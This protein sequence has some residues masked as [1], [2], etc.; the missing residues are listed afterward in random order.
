MVSLSKAN[1]IRSRDSFAAKLSERE[2]CDAAACKR[3]QHIRWLLTLLS[4]HQGL[5]SNS[6]LEFT[7]FRDLQLA[8]HLHCHLRRPNGIVIRQMFK[9]LP[10][11]L[12]A[13]RPNKIE[14]P[15]VLG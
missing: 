8:T 6:R 1:V 2:K 15:P 5:V 11:Q 4:C 10:Q 12:L 7:C 3:Q 14:T 13:V 9:C